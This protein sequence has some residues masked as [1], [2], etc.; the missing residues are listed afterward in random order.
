MQ[1]RSKYL[2]FTA[3][4]LVPAFLVLSIATA[5]ILAYRTSL[6]SISNYQCELDYQPC[7]GEALLSEID[8]LVGKNL[9]TIDLSS[10]RARLLSGDF[11]LREVTITK[12]Y[13]RT[14]SLS[15]LSAYPVVALELNGNAQ[16]WVTLD[17]QYR[18]IAVR[19]ANPNVP[20]LV[21]E[22]LPPFQ[23]GVT[24]EDQSLLDSLSIVRSITDKLISVQRLSL[25]GTTVSLELPGGVTALLTTTRDQDSQLHLLESVLADPALKNS[26]HLIDVRYDRP[27]LK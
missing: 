7:A 9:L 13:P 17:D 15:L 27:V 20:T 11:T 1:A 12:I 3:D 21:V 6:F 5:W 2:V 4:Y 19:D 10:V 23:L 22:S 18:V 24:I 26:Y 8:K 14:L 25:S 16:Q